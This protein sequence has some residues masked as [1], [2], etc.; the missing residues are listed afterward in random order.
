MRLR[1]RRGGERGEPAAEPVDEQIAGE[2]EPAPP[3]RSRLRRFF[4]PPKTRRGLLVLVILVGGFGSVVAMGGITIAKYTETASFCGRC[5]TMDPELKAHALGPHRDVPCAE[6]HVEPGI[7]GFVKAKI[8]GTRQLIEVILDTFPEPIPAPDHA[9]LP[10]VSDSCL[11]CHSLDAITEDG[12]PVK[13][14]LRTR[15]QEDRASTREVIALVVRPSGFGQGS[16]IRG[17]HWH[18]QQEVLYATSDVHAQK[19]PW[20]GVT[21]EDGSTKQYVSLSAVNGVVENV[22]GDIDRLKESTTVKRMDCIDCHNRIGHAV[23]S[24]ASEIDNS[25]ASGKI[26]RAIPYI[27]RDGVELLNGSYP[28]DAAADKAIAALRGKIKAQYPLVWAMNRKQ[29]NASVAE[30]QRL[31]SLVATPDMKV[32][33]RTY[34]SYLGHTTS[35]GCLRCHDGAHFRVVDGNLTNETIPSSCAACHT[36]PQVGSSVNSL[37][38]V[39]EP[40]SH[41]DTLWVFEHKSQVAGADP[42]ATT[43]GNCHTR[44]YCENCHESGAKQVSHDNMKYDHTK[45]IRESGVEACAYCHQPASCMRCHKDD[46][47]KAIARPGW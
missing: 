29:V 36:F 9:S 31:Y 26:S 32:T 44:S 43:C 30:L 35:P 4:S 11:R 15:Y 37:P 39:G 45:V 6:C 14:V 19:I 1:R 17:A 18:V 42:V 7:K 34:P 10:P 16:G 24:V 28:S 27:K 23:P 8:N 22:Q 46:P 25:I 33:A 20:V 47:L 21:Y 41:K 40:D 13:L 2:P 5:H 12:G 38:L 3:K